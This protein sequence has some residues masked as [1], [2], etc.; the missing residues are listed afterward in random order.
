[1][2]VYLVRHAVAHGRDAS[3][4]PDDSGRPLTP[5]GR[6]RFE[7]A[8]VGLTRLVSGVGLMLSS[9]FVRAWQTAEIL[10]EHG[11]PTPEACP[12]LEPDRSPEEVLGVLKEREE[13]GS[14]VLVGHRPNIHAV[15]GYLVFGRAEPARLRIKK[16]GALF[17]R[18][19]EGPEAGRGVL[20]WHL[21]PKVLRALGT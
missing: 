8:A 7:A 10:A 19:E 3:R 11:W 21:P 6:R 5:G 13:V 2:D 12:E 15:A 17:V 9:P 16:G 18:F 14:M 4:W 1:M 20:V